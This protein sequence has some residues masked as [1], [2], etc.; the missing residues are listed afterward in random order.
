VLLSASSA[1]SQNVGSL[2]E[3]ET[4]MALSERDREADSLVRL[5]R[6]TWTEINTATGK[7]TQR[8]S[9][10]WWVDY[11]ENGKR[12]RKSLDTAYRQDA[13]LARGKILRRLR[14]RAAGI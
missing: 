10:T 2:A 4:Q 6:P 8:R 7:R 5:Y 3:R 12:V 13:E 9:S 1:A 11:R 14:E